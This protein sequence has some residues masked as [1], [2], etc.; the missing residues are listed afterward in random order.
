[1][2]DAIE[3]VSQH[4]PFFTSKVS[5]ILFDRF[6][7]AEGTKKQAQPGEPLTSRE[8]EIMQLLAEGKTNKDVGS[9]FGISVKTAETH[10]AA[11]M[12]KLKLDSVTHLVRYAI[13]NGFIEA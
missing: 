6:M 12:R 8:R 3:A 5:E 10:R 7:R 9:Y 11:I 4:K 13:R 1:L 2:I